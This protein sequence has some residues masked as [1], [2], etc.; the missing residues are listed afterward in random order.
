M[1]KNGEK[2]R[3]LDNYWVMVDVVLPS[4]FFLQI[5]GT[6]EFSSV[7]YISTLTAGIEQLGLNSWI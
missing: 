7:Q 5:D 2:V 1:P 3:I 6:L 4:L